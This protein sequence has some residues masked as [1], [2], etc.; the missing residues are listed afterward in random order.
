MSQGKRSDCFRLSRS[1]VAQ[2]AGF[3]QGWREGLAGNF[4]VS[5][6]IRSW[7]EFGPVVFL[8]DKLGSFVDALNLPTEFFGHRSHVSLL[9]SDDLLCVFGPSPRGRVYFVALDDPDSDF[10]ANG[11]VS[12]LPPDVL[13]LRYQQSA[14]V[15]MNMFLML[16]ISTIVYY[17]S[18]DAC[19]TDAR[20][21]SPLTVDVNFKCSHGCH[22]I[23]AW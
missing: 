20:Q 12:V 23:I 6:L 16:L 10:V 4:P 9:R 3:V 2:T 14:N 13:L 17:R 15:E 1:S 21:A 7:P 19:V 8:V 5:A 18:E 22:S 11:E